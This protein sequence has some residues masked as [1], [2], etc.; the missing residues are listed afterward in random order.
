MQDIHI[1]EKLSAYLNHELPKEERQAIAEHLLQCES[2]RREHDEIKF[3]AALASNLK[4]ADAP[5]NLWNEIENALDGRKQS[6]TSLISPQFSFFNSRG[7]LTAAALLVVC[8][9]AAIVYL[10]IFKSESSEIAKTETVIQNKNTETPQILPAPIEVISN[11]NTNKQIQSNI[12]I[13]TSNSNKQT[14]PILSPVAP[15][16]KPYETVT[17]QKDLPAWNVETLA[18]TP[19]AGSRT[20]SQNGKLAVGQFLETD[21]NSRA[22]VQV[23]NIGQV[24]IAPNSRVKLVRTESTEH[25]L[26]LERGVLQAKILAPPRLFIVDTPSAVAVDLG[27]EY[28]LEVDQAGN[29][30]LHVTAGFVALER[31]GRESIVPAGAFCLTKRGKGLGTPFSEE[32]SVEFQ[33]ALFKFDFENNSESVQTIIKESNIYDAL[34]LWHL[35]A[36]V[37]KT[38]REKV[39]DA[40]VSF[41][42]L[43]KGATREGVLRLDKKML[44]QWWKEVENLWFG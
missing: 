9:L 34:T 37:P 14:P 43:P 36:R 32:A 19:M 40:L 4:R 3:G 10:N 31:G 13:Q 11:Q 12:Q 39:F 6:Q 33:N 20:I 5:E 15:A 24:E 18:G 42:E 44:D 41:V 8:G 1:T 28:T 29:S 25:R 16:N 35:L 2:C 30:K 38:E 23:A 27:C 21:A 26:S 7:L 22:R 17:A